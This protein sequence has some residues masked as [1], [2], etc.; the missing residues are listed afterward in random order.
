MSPQSSDF[1][2]AFHWCFLNFFL[3]FYP[4]IPLCA[5]IDAL[6]GS[7]SSSQWEAWCWVML[8]L[9]ITGSAGWRKGRVED[10]VFSLFCSAL[11]GL[12]FV[13]QVS[14]FTRSTLQK[15]LRSSLL[16]VREGC[17]SFGFYLVLID[18][19]LRRQSDTVIFWFSQGLSAPWIWYC[20]PQAPGSA[21]DQRKCWWVLT[22]SHVRPHRP[23]H[24]HTHTHKTT[25]SSF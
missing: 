15:M 16:N 7:C 4:H 9:S 24:L 23:A 6:I 8:H 21:A 5:K 17:V 18:L 19:S 1:H 13:V 12:M 3:A 14:C 2:R 10:V 20:H 11:W 25:I 22:H